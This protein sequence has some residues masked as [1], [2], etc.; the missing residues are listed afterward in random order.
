MCRLEGKFVHV[1]QVAFSTLGSEGTQ[2]YDTTFQGL[3]F[4][5]TDLCF[6]FGSHQSVMQLLK[7][8]R[9]HSEETLLKHYVQKDRPTL[10]KL[11]KIAE[12]MHT[13]FDTLSPEAWIQNGG[14]KK[15]L[16]TAGWRGEKLSA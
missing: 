5:T 2:P 3:P 10:K 16:K 14:V 6:G 13:E 8:K 9:V 4:V 12:G 7:W 15:L 11:L 1:R